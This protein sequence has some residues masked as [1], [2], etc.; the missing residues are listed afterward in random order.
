MLRQVDR[1]WFHP[2][3]GPIPTLDLS[4]SSTLQVL[5]WPTIGRSQSYI[6][7]RGRVGNEP[8]MKIDLPK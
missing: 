3:S 1:F 7:S 5:Q 6:K 8:I 4:R 2:Q